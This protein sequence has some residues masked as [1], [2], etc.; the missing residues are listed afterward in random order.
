MSKKKTPKGA[1]YGPAGGSFAQK[2]KVVLGNVK[3]SGDKKDISLSNSGLG[4]SMY[5]N[6]DSL[7]GNDKDVDM[8]GIHD[9]CFLGLAVI[10]SKAKHIDIGAIFGFSLGSSDFTMN[11]DKI[12]L[13][14]CLSISLK[15]KWIDSKI[16]K[17]PVE[18]SVKKSF[19][20]D[21]DISAVENKSVTAK[22]QLVRKF[23]STINSFGGATTPSK[24]ERIIRSIFI[25]EESMNMTTLLARK[26]DISV[27]T[28]FKKQNIHSNWA[29]V[30]KKIPMDMP[31]KMIVAAV[32]E[33]GNIK[34]IKAEQLA[35]RWSF[36]IKKDS[37]SKDWFRVLLFILPV[38]IMAHDLGILLDRAG[39]KTCVINHSVDTSNKIHCAIIGFKS[40]EDLESAY[41][42]EPIFSSKF[43][44]SVLK[45]DATITS[46]F[47][48]VKP[49]K[50]NALEVIC[51]HLAKLY[52]KKNVTIFCLA[53]FGGRSWAQMALA[54]STSHD[55]S[56]K[57][58]SGPFLIVDIDSDGKRLFLTSLNSSLDRCLSMLKHSLELLTNQVSNI[59][60]QLNDIALVLLVPYPILVLF[61]VVDS[62]VDLDMVLD[63]PDAHSALSSLAADDASVLSSSSTRV[64]TSKV[65]SLE[66][67]LVAFEA[68]IGSV[69]MCNIQDIN[70]PAKQE[71]VMHWHKKSGNMVLFITETK[72]KP[73]TRP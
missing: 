33:F 15:K 57:A 23:F 8:T 34:S 29:V 11:D 68:S 30:I 19:A 56:A 4:N 62:S 9:G 44:H 21:I 22:T 49:F 47:K 39:G 43:G 59:I 54:A 48:P 24:F 13:L 63:I 66:S 17:T 12:V 42:I 65:G 14:F 71:D 31:K 25:L 72:L 10:T 26:K 69:A 36:L 3:H 55:H 37:A 35:S 50:K 41:C 67:K 27:N 60:K 40:E 5:S 16:I 1:F 73:S 70:V 20:L 52:A 46:S 32:S 64:L 51:L 38:R 7:S 53:A 61:A 45:C 6:V 58:G 18:V 28:D 2:K